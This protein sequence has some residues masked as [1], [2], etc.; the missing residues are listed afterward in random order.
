MAEV[1]EPDQPRARVDWELCVRRFCALAVAGVAA[2]ASFEHQR[3]FALRGGADPLNAWLWP[4]SVDGLLVLATVALLKTDA[5]TSRRGRIAACLSFWLGAAVSLVANVAAAPALEWR[6]VLVAGWPPVALLLAVELLA[7]RS[8]PRDHRETAPSTVPDVERDG[9]DEENPEP[10]EV[11]NDTAVGG[12]GEVDAET[13]GE[14]TVESGLAPATAAEIGAEEPTAQEV[15]WA[16]YLREQAR[17]RVP[18]G[19]ELDRVASTNNYGR[20]GCGSGVS[21]AASPPQA[22]ATADRSPHR[23]GGSGDERP[24]SISAR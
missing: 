22:S 6:P 16:H 1:I 4:F 17:G 19:A 20:T 13:S 10:T 5:T 23:A 21:R 3:G 2:F 7:Y 18:T 8:R 14:S 15:M 11:V 12:G 9:A 24:A